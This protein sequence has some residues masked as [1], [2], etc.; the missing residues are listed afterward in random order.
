MACC[1]GQTECNHIITIG[2][3]KDFTNGLIQNGSGVA[4]SVNL[5]AL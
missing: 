2:Y 3:L 4:Q 1:T 5:N